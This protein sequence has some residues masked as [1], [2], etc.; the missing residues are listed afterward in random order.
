MIPQKQIQYIVAGSSYS[1]AISK[2]KHLYFWGKL[3]N[4]QRGEATMYPKIDMNLYGWGMKLCTGGS[5]SVFVVADDSVMAWGVPVAV[6][7]SLL[8]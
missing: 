6:C 2:S 7:V 5:N 1:M 4:S 3:S 8:L